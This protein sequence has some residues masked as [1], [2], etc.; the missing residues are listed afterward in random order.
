MTAFGAFAHQNG[1]W[2]RSGHADGADY[3]FEEGAGRSCIV[4]LPWWG[5]NEQKP[6]HGTPRI[7][8]EVD[9]R[10][11]AIVRKHEPY[12]DE[13]NKPMQLIKC[14]NVYQ[15]LG[16]NLDRPVQVVICW[17][18]GGAAIGGTGLAMKI[19]SDKNIPVLNLED[20][21][22]LN[23]FEISKALDIVVG[24]LNKLLSQTDNFT[25]RHPTEDIFGI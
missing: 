13:L 6:L 11:L 21:P 17:T 18:K 19:A 22:F 3:A 5:F 23:T 2:I 10:A 24:E 20:I 12:V 25:G 4:Y 7:K 1:W 8:E 16:E 14:R 15:I 9:Q